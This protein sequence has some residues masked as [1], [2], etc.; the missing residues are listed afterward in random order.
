MIQKH[1]SAHWRDQSYLNMATEDLQLKQN[2]VRQL[3]EATR[4][5]N[6]VFGQISESIVSEILP[7][8]V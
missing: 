8:T 7:V 5:T 3:T 2:L 4:E 6:K 1:L